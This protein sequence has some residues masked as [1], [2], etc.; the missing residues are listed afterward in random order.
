MEES[1]AVF[2]MGK[3]LRTNLQC[4]NYFG[5]E[6]SIDQMPDGGAD[7]IMPAPKVCEVTETP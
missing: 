5:M 1:P 4:R 3:K 2:L 7:E 6:N